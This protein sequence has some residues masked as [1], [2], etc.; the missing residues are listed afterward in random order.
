MNS[1]IDSAFKSIEEEKEAESNNSIIGGEYSTKPKIMVVG[2]GGAGSNNVNRLAKS[3]VGDAKLIAVNT[4]RMHLKMLDGPGLVKVLIGGKITKGLGAGGFPEV[5]EKSAV[6]SNRELSEV[7]A[8]VNLLFL[9]AGMGGGTGTGAAPVIAKIAKDMGAIV[10]AIVTFPFR[11]ERARLQKAREGIDTLRKVADTVVIIDNKKL[12]DYAPNIPID[13]AFALADDITC[14]A[15]RGI[16]KTIMEPSLVNLDFADL[17]AIMGSGD[18]AMISV[19]SGSGPDKIQQAVNDVLLHPLLDVDLKGGKGALI[20]ITGGQDV[21]LGDVHSIGTMITDSFSRDANVVWGAR[22][23]DHL[24]DSVEVI[25]ILTGVK[26][27]EILGRATRSDE[28]NPYIPGQG[29]GYG[30]RYI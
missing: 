18:V 14:R 25:A 10:V 8:G 12:V 13:K 22:I 4:D 5:G 23:D 2:V 3:G 6:A 9:T 21:T 1:M 29:G 27:E 7:M 16:T 26:C 24:R 28:S 19:G 17:R 30:V 11:L 15:V 20:H